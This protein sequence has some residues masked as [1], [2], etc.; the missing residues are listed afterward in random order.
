MGRARARRASRSYW[1]YQFVGNLSPELL[2]ESE[3]LARVRE[4]DDGW[5]VLGEFAANERGARDGAR[6]SY[7]RDLG[8][9]RLIVID[10]RIGRVL[11]EDRRSMLNAEEWEWL[12]QHLAATSSTC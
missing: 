5:E 2:R 12:E 3:L 4:A 7:C 11:D 1:L 10:S 6:W 8:G 9:T